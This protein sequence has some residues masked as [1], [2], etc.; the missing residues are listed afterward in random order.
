[1]SRFGTTGR[2]RW[3]T[4]DTYTGITSITMNESQM[5]QYP[6]ETTKISDAVSYRA[7]NGARYE[8]QNWSLDSHTFNWVNLD[9]ITRDK[10]YAM[11]HGLPILTFASPPTST[12]WGTFR[13]APDSWSEAET[14]HERYDVSFS[15][16]ELP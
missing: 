7:V 3:N 11:A 1:M 6:F 9:E 13:M 5:P 2:F 12:V 4:G 16:E 10:L 8:Y 15:I 14:S